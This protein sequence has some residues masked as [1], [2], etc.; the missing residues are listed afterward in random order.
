MA[1][2]QTHNKL[3]IIIASWL[4][5]TQ[6]IRKVLCTS[7]PR[8]LVHPDLFGHRRWWGQGSGGGGG[9]FS[10]DSGR[11]R[12]YFVILLPVLKFSY[13]FCLLKRVFICSTNSHSFQLQFQFSFWHRY[14]I[15]W[16]YCLKV[17]QI[18]IRQ[19]G[20]DSEE[21]WRSWERELDQIYHDG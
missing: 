9:G 18:N 3:S 7:S 4:D 14:V 6:I 2:Q 12:H 15:V 16:I 8:K 10:I 11:P 13:Y 5:V 17:F 1:Q 21:A 19:P 20:Q